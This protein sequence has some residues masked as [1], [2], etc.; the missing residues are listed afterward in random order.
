MSF[1]TTRF[2]TTIYNDSCLLQEIVIATNSYQLQQYLS[3]QKKGFLVRTFNFMLQNS[4]Y[5]L[6]EK[7]VLNFFDYQ[8]DLSVIRWEC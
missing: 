2:I 8:N 4:F 1:I 7:K 3:L 5:I 6:L